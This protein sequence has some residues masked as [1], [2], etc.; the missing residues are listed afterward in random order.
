MEKH[1][2]DVCIHDECE[3]HKC[4]CEGNTKYKSKEGVYINLKT[5]YLTKKISTVIYKRVDGK[6]NEIIL[7]KNSDLIIKRNYKVNMVLIIKNVWESA[8]QYGINI[9]C[10]QMVITPV[11]K[12]KI[13]CAFD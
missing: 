1:Q 11:E 12:E 6:P 9:I 8:D 4:L 2:E 10:E 7:Y 13:A 5:D 3:Y